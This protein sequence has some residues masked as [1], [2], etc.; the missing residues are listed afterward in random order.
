MNGEPTTAPTRKRPGKVVALTGAA[1][2]TLAAGT[3]L[4][5]SVASA[6]PNSSS[7]SQSQ[8]K[9]FLQERISRIGSALKGLV[10]DGT[11]TQDQADKVAS[12]LANDMPREGHGGHGHGMHGMRGPGGLDFSVAAKAL[13]LTED[14]LRTELDKGTT[15][16]TLAQ[17]KGV[18]TDNVI[19]ALVDAAKQRL[20]Q[21]VQG[22]R[23][24]QAQADQI[25]SSLTQRITQEV[26]Q[27]RPQR[28][29]RG[30]GGMGMPGG[31]PGGSD[32]S[33]SRQGQDG[34]GSASVPG[35]QPGADGT[36]S[37]QGSTTTPS[38]YTLT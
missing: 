12:T 25:S 34:Q 14:Q 19:T 16:A 30:P 9:N 1:A 17:Q 32:A 2:I 29:E 21:D 15:L 35:G 36:G 33:G 4:G 22:G 27:G 5:A 13:N 37:Q 18:S 31:S 11:I 28:G 20:A 6:A 3:L 7:N 10:S 23:L 24:T 8:E 38:T 26:Q